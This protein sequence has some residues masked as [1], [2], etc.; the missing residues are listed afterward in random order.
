MNAN[1]DDFIVGKSQIGTNSGFEPTFLPDFL[2][3]F[4]KALVDWSI[5]KGRAATFADCG[6]G[7]TPMQLVWAQNMVEHTNKPGLLLTPLSVAAQT[8]REGKNLGFNA[9][10]PATA[11]L[12]TKSPLRITSSFIN[13]TQTILR[14]A[15]AM[16]LPF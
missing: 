14:G 3:P 1:Y 15:A 6:L 11:Q 16:N 5:R 8:V 12:K 10:S 2:F 7:K 9:V 4:Q 13:L